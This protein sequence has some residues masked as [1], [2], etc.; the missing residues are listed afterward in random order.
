MKP[1]PH[2]SYFVNNINPLV[3]SGFWTDVLKCWGGGGETIFIN[4]FSHRGIGNIKVCKVKNFQVW[5]PP[6]IFNQRLKT[7]EVKGLRY[8]YIRT[9]YNQNCQKNN[10]D[11]F[12]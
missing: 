2:P 9:M 4:F 5:V 7:R 11:N 8:V 6:D 12:N 3:H 1:Y 10:K